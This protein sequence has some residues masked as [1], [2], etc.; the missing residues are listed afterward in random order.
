MRK[1]YA[2]STENFKAGFVLLAFPF[3][4]FVFSGMLTKKC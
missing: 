3:V 2:K 4:P 1:S